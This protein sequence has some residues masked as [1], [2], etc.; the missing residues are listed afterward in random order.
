[1][2]IRPIMP[3]LFARKSAAKGTKKAVNPGTGSE[4]NAGL[5]AIKKPFYKTPKFRNIAIGVAA[6]IGAAIAIP[7]MRYNGY[8]ELL[9]ARMRAYAESIGMTEAETYRFASMPVVDG[10]R[11]NSMKEHM[12]ISMQRGFARTV[13]ENILKENGY[14]DLGDNMNTILPSSSL[15]GTDEKKVLAS[16]DY[17]HTRKGLQKKQLDYLKTIMSAADFKRYFNPLETEEN[18]TYYNNVFRR[19]MIDKITFKNYLEENG[20]TS[21][22]KLMEDFEKACEQLEPRKLDYLE[23]HDPDVNHRYSYRPDEDK[24]ETAIKGIQEKF[25]L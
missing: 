11:S 22:S 18:I 25:G 19:Y 2:N 12:A 1:M 7:Q 15:S 21:N 8:D 10:M 4:I 14:E 17:P 13:F 16:D 23:V 20:L 3:R 6:A 5:N 9:E 24:L